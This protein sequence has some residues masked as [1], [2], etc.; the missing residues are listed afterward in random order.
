MPCK[1][2]KKYMRPY[3]P[4]FRL[5]F[6]RSCDH[7]R[8]LILVFSVLYL[9]S[10][11]YIGWGPVRV[12][13]KFRFLSRAFS[14]FFYFLFFL[15]FSFLPFLFSFFFCLFF[16]WGGLL[17]RGP[18]TLSIHAIQSLHHCPQDMSTPLSP[19]TSIS[20]TVVSSYYHYF[21]NTYHAGSTI[22]RQ[23]AVCTRNFT[24]GPR[25][26]S[27]ADL[28]KPLCLYTANGILDPDLTWLLTLADPFLVCAWSVN[29]RAYAQCTGKFRFK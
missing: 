1:L 8:C 7:Y 15:F 9:K 27:I 26:G 24:R 14:S 29:Y 21:P 2:K 25:S 3:F 13:K 6:Q 5:I 23:P 12:F 22:E 19:S 28:S 4:I 16:L 11:G 10:W 17:L 20:P 18:W